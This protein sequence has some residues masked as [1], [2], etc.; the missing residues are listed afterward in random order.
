MN[1]MSF[2]AACGLTAIA[3]N[4]VTLTAEDAEVVVAAD[5]PKTVQ[6]AACAATNFLA[7]VFA[8]PV[9]VVNA[10]SD[11]KAHYVFLRID[12]PNKNPIGDIA[13]RCYLTGLKDAND[14]IG[15][16]ARSLRAGC[17]LLSTSNRRENLYVQGEV[18]SNKSRIS[19]EERAELSA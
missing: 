7:R 17:H 11:G 1:K 2:C 5:A 14:Q 4:A 8:A 10:P 6:F 15:D 9:P 18:P 13:S 16:L 12:S 19:A 3:A